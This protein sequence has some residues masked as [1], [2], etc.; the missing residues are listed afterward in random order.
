MRVASS[1][2]GVS[3]LEIAQRARAANHRQ[4]ISGSTQAG[5]H[6]YLQSTVSVTLDWLLDSL[7]DPNVLKIDVESHEAEALRGA[8]RLL[9]SARP[10]I[11][12]EADP[13]NADAVSPFASRKKLSALR[14]RRGSPS[15]H[16]A[17]RVEY[18]GRAGRERGL[19]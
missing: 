5:G 6:R 8:V 3:E 15:A 13:Q 19:V 2:L 10:V 11:L 7:P 14:I 1:Q 4:G 18:A 12:C 16:P 9:E 17:S